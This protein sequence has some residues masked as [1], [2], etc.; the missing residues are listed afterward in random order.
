[1]NTAYSIKEVV[2]QN[3]PVWRFDRDLYLKRLKEK[4]CARLAQAFLR[5]FAAAAEPVGDL[6]SGE[7]FLK[8]DCQIV[9]W[10]DFCRKLNAAQQRGHREGIDRGMRIA[11]E[12]LPFGLDEGLDERYRLT[13][14]GDYT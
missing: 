9:E 1:M 4:M 5:N 10:D 8:F 3:D 7:L 14:F 12:S 6:A 2:D 11:A 13:E